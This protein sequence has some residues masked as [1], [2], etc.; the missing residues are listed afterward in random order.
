[1]VGFPRR[2][3]SRR[4]R[5]VGYATPLT[6]KALEEVEL[7]AEMGWTTKTRFVGWDA[8]CLGCEEWTGQVMFE[9]RVPDTYLNPAR[10][11]DVTE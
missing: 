2:F 4:E 6:L 3:A 8:G 1:M 9:S 11:F 5:L 10:G 7:V